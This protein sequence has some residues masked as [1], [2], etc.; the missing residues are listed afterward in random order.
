VVLIIT[1][2]SCVKVV[3]INLLTWYYIGLLNNITFSLNRPIVLQYGLWDQLRVDHGKEWY[4]SLFVQEQLSHFRY[5]TNRA[6]HLQTTSKMVS[7]KM[8]GVLCIH[9][10]LESPC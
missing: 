3:I 5:N 10:Y 1:L 8:F 4:L 9:A 6:P 2:F 7:N